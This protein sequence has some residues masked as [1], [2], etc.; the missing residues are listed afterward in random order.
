MFR[1]KLN[2]LDAFYESRIDELKKQM[3]YIA[4]KIPMVIKEAKYTK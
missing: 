3:S 1:E 4:N 2:D